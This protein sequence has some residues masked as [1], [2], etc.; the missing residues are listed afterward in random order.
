MK[1]L[2]TFK[3]GILLIIATTQKPF[4]RIIKLLKNTI[5]VMAIT[6][7][8]LELTQI[9]KEMNKDTPNHI[10]IYEGHSPTWNEINAKI[11][12]LK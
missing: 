11:N 3:I 4:T 2:K 12:E 9:A 6:T 8:P 5:F 10:I 7:M 1:A